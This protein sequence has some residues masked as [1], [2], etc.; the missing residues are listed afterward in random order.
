LPWSIKASFR[1]LRLSALHKQR[2]LPYMPPKKFFR[3]Y[4]LFFFFVNKNRTEQPQ[5]NRRV[6]NTAKPRTLNWTSNEK[7]RAASALFF[8]LRRFF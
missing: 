1:I 7:Q 3:E 8:V 4:T 5:K 6:R 2:P